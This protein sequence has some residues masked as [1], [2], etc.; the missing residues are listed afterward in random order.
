MKKNIAQIILIVLIL[1]FL[2]TLFLHD[3]L[4][5]KVLLGTSLMVSLIM[6]CVFTLHK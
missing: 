3:L 6:W 5:F 4:A 2:V 1:I